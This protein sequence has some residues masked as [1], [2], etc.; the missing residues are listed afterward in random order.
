MQQIFAGD[1]DDLIKSLHHEVIALMNAPVTLAAGTVTF[2]G[3]DEWL[4]EI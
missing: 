2:L 3:I 1:F 4:L